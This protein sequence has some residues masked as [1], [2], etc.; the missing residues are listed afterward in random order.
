MFRES[1]TGRNGDPKLNPA[2]F[3]EKWGNSKLKERSGY[4]EHFIDLCYVVGHQTPAAVD[5][6]GA[7][8]CFERGTQKIEGGQ[9]WADVW[10]RG[11]FGWEY[12]G[13]NRDLGAAYQQ[14]LQYREA[15]ENPPL[16]VVCDF[17]RIVIHTNFTNTPSEIYEVSLADLKTERGLKIL[18]WLFH[19][20]EKLR[21]GITSQSITASAAERIALIARRLRERGEDP[22]VVA[23]FLDR[24]VFC[25]FAEDIEL[26]PKGLFTRILERSRSDPERFKKL[27]RDLFGAMATGGDFGMDEI[28]HFNGSLF[29][30]ADVLD[31]DEADLAVLFEAAQL[32]WDAVDPSIFGTLFERGLDPDKRT[33]LGAHYTSRDDIV[34]LIE[35]VLMKPLRDE[36]GV[37]RATSEAAL[38]KVATRYET[39][40]KKLTEAT[41]RKHQKAAS[42]AVGRFLGRLTDIKILDPACG[43]GN[44]LYVS[45]QMLKDFEKEVLLWA[46]DHGLEAPLPLVHPRQLFGIE[47]SPYAYD[48]AQMTVWIGHLQWVRANGFGSPPEPILRPLRGNFRNMD[49]I[50]TGIDT[51][52]ATE[53]A[54]PD[55]DVIVGNPP[56]LGGKLL[57]T[58]LGDDY[59]DALFGLWKGRVPAEADLCCYWF[60]KARA[61]VEAGKCKR[62]GLLATQGI[63]GGANREVLKRIRIR[64]GPRMS[65][66]SLPGPALRNEVP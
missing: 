9:G 30:S 33:Q 59:V 53:P 37:V 64:E 52:V 17:E 46:M 56:F 12:K 29:E 8:F 61:M 58:N 40:G 62:A 48:L 4:Q 19:D 10:K 25:M 47:L 41:I 34:A 63:R 21:P 38:A 18:R 43:S 2:E 55:V 11:Y 44:F 31:V 26:L 65:E 15:L 28:Q 39:G 1:L 27:V 3:A 66:V 22:H 49:A 35:P 20:P 36:W 24:I 45:L 32:D 6:S 54:W 16:L 57:R 23:R 60:E 50:V 42:A 51:G 13:K 14:L 7:S 5:P